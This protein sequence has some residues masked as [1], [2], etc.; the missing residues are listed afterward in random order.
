MAHI[1]GSDDNFYIPREM[2]LVLWTFRGAE[3]W[4]EVFL[5]AMLNYVV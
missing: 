3:P 4:Y 2:R 1:Y 5:T